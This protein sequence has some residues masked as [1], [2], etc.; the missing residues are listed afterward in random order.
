MKNKSNKLLCLFGFHTY[1]PKIITCSPVEV[2]IGHTS[3]TIYI[4]FMII[5]SCKYCKCFRNDGIF[6]TSFKSKKDAK[7]WLKRRGY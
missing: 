1:K 2:N 5:F 7:R 6:P 3:K 4:K